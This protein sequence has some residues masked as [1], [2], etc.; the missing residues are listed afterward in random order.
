MDLTVRLFAGLKC[1]NRELACYG[2]KEFIIE[3][4]TGT[5]LGQLL[6]FLGIPA[7]MGKIILVNGQFKPLTQDLIDGDQV[8][9]F[10]PI[11]GG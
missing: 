10:P 4:Q 2:Q 1:E 7:E 8:S 6:D 11:G 9:I 5:N 3:L